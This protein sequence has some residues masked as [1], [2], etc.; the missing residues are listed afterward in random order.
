MNWQLIT[1]KSIQPVQTNPATSV[2]SCK[3]GVRSSE[4]GK[5]IQSVVNIGRYYTLCVCFGN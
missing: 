3:F 5:T 4:F 2:I 1:Y